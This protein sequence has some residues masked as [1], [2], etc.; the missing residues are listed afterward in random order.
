MTLFKTIISQIHVRNVDDAQLLISEAAPVV[1]DLQE[2]VICSTTEK[3]WLYCPNNGNAVPCVTAS[4]DYQNIDLYTVDIANEEKFG[5][6]SRFLL[7]TAFECRFCYEGIVSLHAA[8]VENGECAIA[9]TGSS[10]TG[11]ST[12]A[13][14]WTDALGFQWISGDR[15]A[16]RLQ[17]GGSIACGVPWDGKEQIFRDVERPLKAILEVRR[18]SVNYVRKL[19]TEQAHKV[20]VR[21]VFIPMWDTDAAVMALANV[22]VL[23]EKTPVYR[24]FCGP[25]EED[26]R[27][28]YEI[29]FSHPEKIGKEE[30]EMKIRD[31]FVLRNIVDEYIVM[32]TG[33]NIVK[34]S[35]SVVLNEVSAFIFKQ[36][37]NPV[38]QEDLLTAMLDEFDVDEETAR[39]DLDELLREFRELKLIED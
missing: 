8:C 28:I 5:I 29:L 16:V 12:R 11:K 19:T 26:A 39:Q 13:K 10:G 14:A 34:F 33:D 38:T 3:R 22:R 37:E 27:E 25:D 15:P 17:E 2:V 21:Q 7:R 4:A 9:F 32:P 30:K 35:G 36:L 1:D 18:S 23:I 6:G 20:L 24:V 31:G